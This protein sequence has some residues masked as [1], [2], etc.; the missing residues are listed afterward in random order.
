MALGQ[1]LGLVLPTS[2]HAGVVKVLQHTW[3]E[4]GRGRA[5]LWLE[6]RG[7]KRESSLKQKIP[8]ITK[9]PLWVWWQREEQSRVVGPSWPGSGL[10]ARCELCSPLS[11][12][13]GQC[14]GVPW[15]SCAG[16]GAAPIPLQGR[17][18]LL[19]L[20]PRRTWLEL[21][22]VAGWDRGALLQLRGAGGA[23]GDPSQPIPHPGPRQP[24]EFPAEKELPGEE[25]G[26]FPFDVCGEGAFG[27]LSKPGLRVLGSHW[28]LP[29]SPTGPWHVGLE[30]LWV[31]SSSS[32]A[33][34]ERWPMAS[35]T[36]ATLW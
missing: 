34:G 31:I 13:W 19:P 14:L 7:K 18:F 8:P 27:S 15:G 33:E 10:G 22:G 21:R 5:C 12:S 26:G 11:P 29:A 4:Q 25:H 17:L 6:G 23:W 3:K 36:L 28:F 20:W 24:W 30:P 32:G 1:E 2:A 35:R 9:C 16:G